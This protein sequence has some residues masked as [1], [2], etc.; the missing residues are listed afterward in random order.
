MMYFT[1][2]HAETD[3]LRQ[4]GPDLVEQVALL[5]L[6]IRLREP[7]VHRADHVNALR[8]RSVP[9][10][11][12]QDRAVGVDVVKGAVVEQQLQQLAEL[13]I[14]SRLTPTPVDDRM[15][16]QLPAGDQLVKDGTEWIRR[17]AV[18]ERGPIL[19]LEKAVVAGDVAMGV[20]GDADEIDEILWPGPAP[21]LKIWATEAS[22]MAS[23]PIGRPDMLALAQELLYGELA[24]V[25]R[26]KERQP[27]VMMHDQAGMEAAAV[28]GDATFDPLAAG[29]LLV[30]RQVQWTPS[31]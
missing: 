30:P 8:R 20:V 29:V 4:I 24:T 5:D 18:H 16:C 14:G 11:R 26:R 15:R 21:L 31:C 19:A 6:A 9:D 23:L 3:V 12:R 17:E 2:V 7:G 22:R 28:E 1:V 25:V 27:S 13:A 10:R